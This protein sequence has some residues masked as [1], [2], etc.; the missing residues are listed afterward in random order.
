[1]RPSLA[2]HTRAGDDTRTS[3]RVYGEKEVNMVDNAC[4]E[5]ERLIS[6]SGRNSPTSL[7]VVCCFRQRAV[8]SDKQVGLH[9]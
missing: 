5:K 8:I 6:C 1:M 4:N 9:A 3:K 2:D 7:V